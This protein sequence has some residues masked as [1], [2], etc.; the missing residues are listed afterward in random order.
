MLCTVAPTGQTTSQGAFSHCMHGTGWKYVFGFVRRALV[1]RSMRSQCMWRPRLICSLPTTGILFSAW[2]A[3]THAL[4]PM[5]EFMS[6]VMPH[7]ASLYSY[8][9]TASD[10][11][12]GASTISWAKPGS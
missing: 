6:I 9:Y 4:Q 5:Q 10:R 12:G 2:H 11:G 1:D 8:A 7:L 3:T